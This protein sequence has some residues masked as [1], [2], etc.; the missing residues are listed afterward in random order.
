MLIVL[1]V[2]LI[3]YM[4]MGIPI[5]FAIGLSAIT[6]L[7]LQGTVP[8]D[9][10]AQ[11]IMSGAN[12]LPLMA[13]P[14]FILAG[15][16]MNTGGVTRRLFGFANALVGHIPGGLGHVCMVSGIIFASMSGSAVADAAG[17][18]LIEA[19]AMRDR[20][21]PRPF[22]GAV[23]AAASVISPIIPPSIAGVIYAVMANVSVGKMLIAGIV[24]GFLM[25]VLMMIAVYV[26]A[27]RAGYPVEARATCGQVVMSF[28]GAFLSLLTPVVI[29]GAIYTGVATPTEAA[30]LAVVYA[31]G[32]GLAY[33]EI[34]FRDVPR[35]LGESALSTASTMAIIACAAIFSWVMIYEQVPAMVAHL[36]FS[37]TRDPNLIM[38]I[39]LIAYLILGCF[40]ES[41][42][43]I[44]L[45]V[46]VILPI[47]VQVGIDPIHFGMVMMVNLMIGLLTPPVGVCLYV[48]ANVVKTSVGQMTRA[49]APFYIALLVANVIAAYTPQLV[50]WLPNLMLGK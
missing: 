8:L 39:A 24:P 22:T 10:I 33:G 19:K 29:L 38:A 14:F 21:F 9:I 16:L 37:V 34:R 2:S 28:K 46:P 43:I 26:I 42:A 47:I 20:G 5:A 7:A 41:V 6:F 13:I 27:K 11:Q 15:T 23:V 49:L 31:L 3:L 45:T 4:M 17:I 30:V 48:V 12:S 25:A 50:L 35:V 1:V 40:M 18:G 36:I 44:M 32:L